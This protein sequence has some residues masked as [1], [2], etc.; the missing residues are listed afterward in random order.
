MFGQKRQLKT[1]GRYPDV[2]LADAR[3]K[4][5]AVMGSQIGDQPPGTVQIAYPEARAKFLVACK[6]RLKPRSHAEMTRQLTAYFTWDKALHKITHDD[7]AT[8]VE[9]IKAPSEALH[10]FKN[11]RTFFNWSVPRY[12]KYSPVTGLKPPSRYIPR[13]RA[14]NEGEL[15]SIWGAADREGYPFGTILKMLICTG[16]RLNEIAS[17]QWSNVN[18]RD[19]T[20]TF[21]VTKN[22]RSHTIPYNGIVSTLLETIPRLNS[23]PLLFPSKKVDKVWAGSGP[24]KARLEMHPPIRP[25]VIH[26]LRRTMA[27]FWQKMRVRV[28]H[29]EAALNHL[30]G[31]RSGI[32]GVYQ[33]YDYRDELRTCYNQWDAKLNEILARQ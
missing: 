6:S 1:L 9:A 31:S 17:L 14:L 27:H 2:S 25:W 11:I 24:G 13:T 30:S 7:V 18:T 21:P 33:V 15:Q 22:G 26:D 4:A 8:A 29:T 20:L 3:K 5:V 23:T 16:A 19:K 32:V 12:L 10:A 28:E